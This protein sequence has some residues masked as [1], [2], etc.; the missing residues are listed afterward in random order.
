MKVLFLANSDEG[1]YQFRKELVNEIKKNHEVVLCIPNGN[2]ISYFESIGCKVIITMMNRHGI[3]PFEEYR[4]LLNYKKILKN[5]KPD[6]VFTYTIKPNVY[7]GMA[8][9]SLNIPYVANITGLGTAIENG[10]LMQKISLILY[11]KGLKKAKKVF[12]QN[13]SNQEF[14][15][16]KGLVSGEYDL[17]P[18]S[19]VNV[20]QFTLL[21]YPSDYQ[22]CFTFIARLMKE[23]GIEQYLDAA[24]F[25]HEK[26]PNTLFYICGSK[27]KEYDM[28]RLEQLISKGVVIY[29]GE[30]RDMIPIYQLSSC[31]IHPTYYPEGLSNVLLESCACGRPIITT[32]RPGC[33]E[34]VDDGINGFVVEAKNSNN[35]IEKIEL[36]L[37][38]SNNERRQMG[39][40]GR[41]KVE[42]EFN[43]QLVINKYLDEMDT[44]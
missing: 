40:E 20:N 16:G 43:R 29:R 1:L 32:D 42:K 34:V 28:T 18:G 36:F 39:V 19:G 24:E 5:E 37:S 38:K 21:D 15:I 6:I 27:E 23:K 2:F 33:R 14:M 3:N 4:L 35:L 26:Y 17:L 9:A 25:I 8:C 10:G 44:I 30:V 7:G 41:N 11:K 31:V 13:R 22:I 12:F